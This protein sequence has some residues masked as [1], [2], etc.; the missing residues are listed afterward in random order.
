[1]NF[2]KVG[3]YTHQA[4]LGLAAARLAVPAAELSVTDGSVSG[5]GK[6][7][8]YG[9]LVQGQQLDLKIPI[10]G[11][12]ARVDATT[13]NGLAGLDGYVVAGDPPMRPIGQYRVV[14]KSYPMP[15]IP[16]KVTGRT[17]W[18]CDVRLPG[19]LHARMIR[20][21][22]LGSTLL[23]LG[24]LDKKRF[25]TA[26]V[27]RKNNL[28]AVVSPDEWE[29]IGAARAVANTTQW[30]AWAGLPGSENLTAALRAVNWGAPS[31]AHGKAETVTASLAGAARPSRRVTSS[32]MCATPPWVRLSQL[33]R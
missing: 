28:V 7:I 19:M 18:S 23:A 3:A 26:Q 9:Q 2:R 1:M 14:G 29:A 24:T 31:E 22:T 6:S 11:T 5:G 15:G 12:P 33:L 32:R 30:T 25:P 21:A 17:Q 13:G 8:S 20:P 4:L 10:S 16:D 27:V